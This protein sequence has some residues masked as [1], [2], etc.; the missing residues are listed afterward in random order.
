MSELDS[1]PYRDSTLDTEARVED[2]VS[3]MELEEKV[4]QLGCVW[5]TQLV[6]EAG[7]CMERAR[8]RLALGTGQVTRIGATTGLRPRE[9]ARF[10]NAIQEFLR[11]HTR[12]GIPALVH[13]ESCAGFCA[14]DADQFPPGHRPRGQLRPGERRSGRGLDPSADA[15]SGRSPDPG[16]GAR[17]RQGSALGAG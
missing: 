14:R 12:L 1:A 3:R 15:G 16:P 10:M 11:Q 9:S 7:F 17:H 5:S 6:G 2:L 4:A 13:E 8:E